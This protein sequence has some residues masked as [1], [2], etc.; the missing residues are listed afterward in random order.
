MNLRESPNGL[1]Y[2]S[3][4]LDNHGAEG[5][6]FAPQADVMVTLQKQK[7]FIRAKWHA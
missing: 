3:S 6:G 1:T 5:G 7:L 4:V 2:T